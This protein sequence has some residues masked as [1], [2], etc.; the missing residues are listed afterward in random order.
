MTDIK[1]PK[2]DREKCA[3]CGTCEG[4]C[5]AVFK[6]GE[7]GIAQVKPEAD[8]AKEQTAIQEAIDSCP[9]GAIS[10]EE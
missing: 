10:W 9:I 4:I 8:F 2:I 1:K 6:L 5:P 3:G 7:D